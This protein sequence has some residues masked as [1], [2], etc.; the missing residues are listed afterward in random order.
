MSL[1]DFTVTK[2]GLG[3]CE[4]YEIC[5]MGSIVLEPS[6]KILA[7]QW[8]KDASDDITASFCW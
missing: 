6:F 1:S 7:R 3:E 8:N 2:F 5:P 4:C